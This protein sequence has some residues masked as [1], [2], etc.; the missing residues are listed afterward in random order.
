MSDLLLF[1]ILYFAYLK[2]LTPQSV[3]V[4]FTTF[5]FL[6]FCFTDF[7]NSSAFGFPVTES[8]HSKSPS[9]KGRFFWPNLHILTVFAVNAK[10]WTELLPFSTFSSDTGSTPS[11]SNPC[12]RPSPHLLPPEWKRS[13]S[14]CRSAYRPPHRR[15]RLP[16][17]APA[18]RPA[19]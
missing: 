3:L 7:Y 18:P 17:P 14:S 9:A 13:R 5:N 4:Q 10:A 6:S 15:H 8:A 19:G 2:L 11:S 12:T 16:R 1:K